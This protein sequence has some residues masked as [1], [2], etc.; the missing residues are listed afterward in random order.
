MA[1]D[2]DVQVEEAPHGAQGAELPEAEMLHRR[3]V[4]SPFLLQRRQGHQLRHT[5]PIMMRIFAAL[6]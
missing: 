5:R 2:V 3:R 6:S 1:R 4:P